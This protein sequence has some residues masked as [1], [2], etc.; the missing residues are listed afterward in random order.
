[1]APTNKLTENVCV[2]SWNSKQIEIIRKHFYLKTWCTKFFF[3]ESPLHK[4]AFAPVATVAPYT[5]S[6]YRNNLLT[7]LHQAPFK[8]HCFTPEAFY[9]AKLLRPKTL[10]TRSLFCRT[11]FRQSQKPFRPQS[12]VQTRNLFHQSL[13][14]LE[15]FTPEA[16]FATKLLHQKGFYTTQHLHQP[17]FPPNSLYTWNLLHTKI[18]CSI[19]LRQHRFA[20]VALYT[21]YTYSYTTKLLSHRP[22][23]LETLLTPEVGSAECRASYTHKGFHGKV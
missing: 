13:L 7:N 14:H 12:R 19:F 15:P 16:F 10:Y 21:K 9:T 23:P 17:T 4:W 11:A 22:F 1:M 18:F 6:F 8:P 2:E 5:T 3:A 20:S